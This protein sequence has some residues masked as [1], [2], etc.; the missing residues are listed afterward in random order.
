MDV[1]ERTVWPGISAIIN[2]PDDV[3]PA[4]RVAVA[5]WLKANTE[6]WLDD[7]VSVTGETT[8]EEVRIEDLRILE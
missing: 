3:D 2:L 1:T 5:A 6:A 7:L 8:T 4:D